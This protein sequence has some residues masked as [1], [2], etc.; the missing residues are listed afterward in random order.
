ML[1]VVPIAILHSLAR[2]STFYGIVMISGVILDLVF[3]QKYWSYTMTNFYNCDEQCQ[4]DKQVDVLGVYLSVAEQIKILGINGVIISAIF[5]GFGAVYCTYN[6]FNFFSSKSKLYIASNS[7]LI[8]LTKNIK[9]NIQKIVDAKS[10]RYEL[11][12]NVSYSSPSSI[13]SWFKGLIMNTKSN[14]EKDLEN[15]NTE[16]L[17]Y[18]CIHEEYLKSKFHLDLQ[19]IILHKQKEK[20]SKSLKGKIYGIFARFLVV[21]GVYKVIFVRNI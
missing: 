13:K 7:D 2:N 14:Q 10:K 3:I 20:L 4:I 21:Y 18:E 1:Y 5:S 11:K 12:S 6:Y 9:S 15:V 19:D 16:I 17:A 8:D